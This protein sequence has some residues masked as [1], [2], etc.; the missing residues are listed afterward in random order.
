MILVKVNPDYFNAPAL[1]LK[2]ESPITKCKE[3]LKN[4]HLKYK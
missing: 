3:I 2:I 1:M 4:R